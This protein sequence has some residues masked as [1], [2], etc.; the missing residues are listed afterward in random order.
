[1]NDE[2]NEYPSIPDFSSAL[3]Q[4]ITAKKGEV[5]DGTLP[6]AGTVDPYKLMLKRKNE[7]EGGEI[8]T[9]NVT[10]WPEKDVKTLQDYCLKMGI[11]GF[12]SGKLPPLVAL[13]Q[14]KKQLGDDYTDVPLENRIPAGYEKMG[15]IS[16]YTSNFPYSEMM[17]KK[18]ILHG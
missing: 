2:Y 16:P 12:S 9:S 17:K 13:A 14:L 15:T 3:M 6:P 10:Q 5:G 4:R 11:V 8:D 18:Q 7:A 1:M